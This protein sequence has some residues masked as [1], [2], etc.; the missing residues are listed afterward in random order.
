LILLLAAAMAF[1][2]AFAE[3][4]GTGAER[5]DASSLVMKTFP[6]YIE[7]NGTEP[8][9]DAF[10]LY[11]ADGVDDLPYV[12]ISSVFTILN[13][14]NGYDTFDG[15]ELTAELDPEAE[16]VTIRLGASDSVLWFDFAEQ[17]AAYSQFQRPGD[18]LRQ[19]RDV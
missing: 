18:L 16:T 13:A 3:D 19:P 17:K 8:F 4:G 7:G 2:G 11:F 5:A 1:S 14:T 10:P 12:N 15:A 9:A 6:L